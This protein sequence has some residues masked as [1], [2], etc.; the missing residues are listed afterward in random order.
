[1]VNRRAHERSILRGASGYVPVLTAVGARRAFV[2][3]LMTVEELSRWRP[4]TVRLRDPAIGIELERLCDAYFNMPL[5][6]LERLIEAESLVTTAELH[7]LAA[8]VDGQMGRGRRACPPL[9]R[10]SAR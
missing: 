10:L 8:E 5:R 2:G 4:P 6:A 1:M 3:R 7:V 9:D